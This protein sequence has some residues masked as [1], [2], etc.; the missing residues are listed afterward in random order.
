[1]LNRNILCVVA[2]LVA[3]A[4]AHVSAQEKSVSDAIKSFS[5][6]QSKGQKY[7]L[8]YKMKKGEKFRWQ[9]DHQIL[10]KSQVSGAKEET[11]LTRTQ[12]LF[13]WEVKN[14]DSRDQMRFEIMM[15]NISVFSRIGKEDPVTYNSKDF[16]ADET[17]KVPP[18]CMAYHERLGRPISSYSIMPNG[19]IV[20]QKSK[21]PNVKLGGVGEAPV[22]AFPNVA[23]PVGHKWNIHEG[24][25]ARDE[26]GIY[27]TINVRVQYELQKIVDGKAYIAFETDVLDPLNS[28]KV[29]SQIINHLT[30]GIAVFDLAKGMLVHREI[31]WDEKVVGYEGPDSFLQYQAKRVEKLVEE[32]L[33]VAGRPKKPA[34]TTPTAAAS[35]PVPATVPR[36]AML[37]PLKK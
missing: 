24:L 2:L 7:L 12:S 31:R 23:I 11:T 6:R 32:T 34:A 35:T 5:H 13:V 33:T 14:I 30:R 4:A 1:M 3:T 17:E 29:H 26:H 21:Y 20:A 19:T 15:D 37:Q 10:N 27:R 22:V 25:K 18:S 36:R 16:T 8:K 9:Q 28:E